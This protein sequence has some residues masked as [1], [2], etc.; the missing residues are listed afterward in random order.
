[1]KAKLTLNGKE[2]EVEINEEQV[3][4]IE[5]PKYKKWRAEKCETY[6]SINSDGTTCIHTDFGD[7]IDNFL[8]SIGNYFRTEEEA[9]EY[10]KKL[11][12]LQ[13]YKD[14]IGEDLL[15]E[16]DFKNQNIT[17]YFAY[18]DYINEDI[19]TGDHQVI[20]VQGC[21]YSKSAQKIW[22]FVNKIGRDDFKKYILGIN[23]NE[24]GE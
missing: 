14:F 11:L 21:I 22:D 5:K 7:V 6:C 20:R 12:Y 13:Q 16:E 23:T 19:S 17:K 15:T 8:Y 1:M 18:Y 24:E 10:K 2:Y 3:K 4:E 9:E